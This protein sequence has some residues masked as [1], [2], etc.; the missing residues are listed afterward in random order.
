MQRSSESLDKARERVELSESGVLLGI[1]IAKPGKQIGLA[2]AVGIEL[3]TG[4]KITQV[5]H[6]T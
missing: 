2:G 4:I 6:F 5:A 1:V 3:H